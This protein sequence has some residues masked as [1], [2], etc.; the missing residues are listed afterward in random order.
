MDNLE[1]IIELFYK[2][3][4]IQKVIEDK[5]KSMDFDQKE[6]LSMTTAYVFRYSEIESG[7]LLKYF[8]DVFR[9]GAKRKGRRISGGLSVFEPLF[10]YAQEFLLIRNNEVRCRYSRLLA[11]R[12]ITTELSQDL[13]VTAFFAG[14]L[15]HDQMR[16][17]GF[18]WKSV[19]DHDNAQINAVVRRGISENHF[20]LN[21]AAPIFQISWL[22]LMNNVNVSKLGEY[23]RAY[24]KKRRYTNVAYTSAYMEKSFQAK[25]MQAALIRLLL[26][27]K[28]C[29]KRLKMGRYE[30]ALLDIQKDIAFPVFQY[31]QYGEEPCLTEEAAVIIRDRVLSGSMQHYADRKEGRKENALSG[32]WNYA[33][34]RES[35]LYVIESCAGAPP[36]WQEVWNLNSILR[37]ILDSSAGDCLLDKSQV[38]RVIKNNVSIPLSQLFFKLF[39]LAGK[40]DLEVLR[41]LFADED[42][43]ESIWE[44]KTLQN[45]KELLKEPEK[46][47]CEQD[48]LQ[49]LIDVYRLGDFEHVRSYKSLDYILAHLKFKGSDE[50]ADNYIFSGE[51]WLMYVMLRKV[52]LND[53]QYQKYFN[54]FYA[55]LLI[56]ESIRSELIQSNQN[57]GFENFSLYQKRKGDLLSDDI[58]KKE[59]TRHA[60]S[61]SL[62]SKNI[63]KI[64]VRIAPENNTEDMCRRIQELDS[65]LLLD[66]TRENDL[67]YTVHFLKKHDETREST[68]LI[69]CR[70]YQRRKLIE[71]QAYALTGLREKWPIVGRRVLGI[72]AAASEI[73]CRPEVFASVFRYLKNHRHRY[74]SDG[75]LRKLPQLGAT[76]HVGED[77]LDLADG[78]RAMEEA[79]LFLNLESGDRL[80]HALALGVNVREWYQG[81]GNR[82]ALPVQDYLD[83]LV[84]IFQKLVQYDI[85]GFENLKDWIEGEYEIMFGRIYRRNMSQ[86]EINEIYQEFLKKKYKK[87]YEKN[88]R[89]MDFGIFNYYYAWQLRGDDPESYERGYFY[90]NYY[91]GR[92]EEFRV[93]FHY[94]KD[95]QKREMPEAAFLYYMY[96]FNEGVR[97]EGE[98]TKEILVS[99]IYVEAVAAIQKLMQREIAERG[100]AIETNPSSN[101][102]I[103]TFRQY[104]KHPIIQFYNKGLVHDFKQLKDCPQL[105]VSINTDDQGVFSTSLENEYALMARALESVRDETGR[106]VYCRDDICEW[107]DRIRV[108]GN[109]QSF[110]WNMERKEKAEDV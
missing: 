28:V 3:I 104:E 58:Y 73:G 76:Y 59:F 16:M 43:Y 4:P 30:V 12:K 48:S 84:W 61:N 44:N 107:L 70:H 110:W 29:E 55:Y 105:P 87:D 33:T 49:A 45:V 99:D 75:D 100:I 68:G 106:P 9:E 46:L 108:M 85:H 52:Y 14:E 95:F 53:M 7:N 37:K 32:Q 88:I 39:L 22:S 10:Y 54:L 26:Y 38:V 92:Q 86:T 41:K 27:C 2:R 25:Y 13:L 20:H 34:F 64:E 17:R 69:H 18:A 78:L 93:N 89:Q 47:I 91:L 56:R 50:E 21:G 31:K 15:T 23:L 62:V 42:V 66:D 74:Y 83:N 103:G 6:F 102:L 94:L 19:I 60:V 77:F 51:R 1:T 71:R 96:H 57:V 101:Y 35:V 40:A 82:I 72:D 65:M 11:W 97:K 79:I 5:I 36:D 90:E 63:R 81:K 24:D 8:L 80:G 109:E 98:K 67:F